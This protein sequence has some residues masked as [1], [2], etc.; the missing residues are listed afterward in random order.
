MILVK[1]PAVFAAQYPSLPPGVDVL[2]PFQGRLA[3]GG[4]QLRLEDA[5]GDPILDFRFNDGWYDITDGGGFSLTIKDVLRTD[6]CAWGEKSSWRPS[7]MVGGSPGWD[8][9][10]QIPP[11]GSVTINEILAHSHAADPDWIELRN[12]TPYTINLGGWYLSDDDDNLKKYTV[13]LGT[14]L[15]PCYLPG[16]F[17]VFYENLHFGVGNPVDPSNIPFALSENGETLYLHS[18]LAGQLTGYS[19]EEDFGASETD[20]AFGRYQK[21]TGTY[22]FVAMST[23]TPGA[24]NAYPKVGPLVISEIMYHPLNDRD[25]EYVELHNITSFPLPL[26]SY[27]PCTAQNIPWRFTD[28]DGITFDFPLGTFLLAGERI[29]LVKNLASF[30]AEF[31]STSTGVRKF[32]WD[33]GRLDNGGEKIQ[34]SKPGEELYGNRQYIRVDRVVYSDGSHPDPPAPDPWPASPDGGGAAL[35]RIVD[36]LYGNDVINWQ[37][38]PPSPGQ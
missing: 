5:V 24:P 37:A 17:I 14:V 10:G 22:N 38:A 31:P 26:W 11:L 20:V 3:N 8:D 19:E 18:G 36:S 21:S 13:P 29:L 32:E 30:Y 27:D 7:A 25:A 28:S 6:P 2:G 9:S 35:A 1:N 15:D 12:T 33:S 16:S 34:V 23:N 4:E